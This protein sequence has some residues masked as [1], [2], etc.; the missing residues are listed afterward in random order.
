[1]RAPSRVLF[2]WGAFEFIGMVQ[3]Y[4][5]TLD[6]FSPK[7][8]P[9][10]ARLALKLSEDRY[11]FRSNDSDAQ[12]AEQS[13][14]LSFTG[15]GSDEEGSSDAGNGA[16]APNQNA[17]PV[18]GGS[19]NG[20]G[21]WRDNAM[22]NGIESPRLPTAAALA[23]PS[24]GVSASVGGAAGMSASFGASA[25]VSASASANATIGVTAAAGGGPAFKFGNSSALG[26]GIPG[27]FCPQPG[28]G[29]NAASLQQGSLQLRSTSTGSGSQVSSLASESSALAGTPV[30]TLLKTRSDDG[31]GFE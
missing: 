19:D 27:A 29:L 4:D 8:R 26:T 24:V 12:N 9:L 30:S 18:P 20:P 22:F 31:V 2:Q 15:N 6:F 23:L 3:T 7:G 17:S 13:P 14:T 10:R 11:Q 25:G 1:M 5:E 28:A 16:S 21:N